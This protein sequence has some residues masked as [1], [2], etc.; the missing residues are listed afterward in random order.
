MRALLLVSVLGVT[1]VR[2]GG[3]ENVAVF[4]NGDSWASLAIANEYCAAR[5][6]PPAH[7]VVLRDL[8]S[9]EQVS[10]N[11]FREKILIP[12]LTELERRGLAAQ[13]DYVLYSSDFPTA[14]EVSADTAGRTFP[15]VITQPASITGL[16]FLYKFTLAKNPGYLGLNTNFYYRQP[17]QGPATPAMSGL[18]RDKYSAVIAKFQQVT[19]AFEER[20]KQDAA[21]ARFTADEQQILRD[22]RAA[23]E[24]FKGQYPAR[25]EARYDLAC[26]LARLGEMD[27]A[28]AE[29]RAAMDQG[30]W[31]M[32]RAQQDADFRELRER[33]GF[34]ELMARAR[35][36]KFDLWPTSGFRGNVGWI[37]TGAPVPAKEGVS[38]LLSAMLACTSGRGMGVSEAIDGLKR[39]VKADGTR[40][41]G[42]VYFLEN[43]DIRSTTRD[44]AFLRAVEKLREVG[45]SARV[46][47]GILPAKR[48]DVAGLTAGA[49]DFSWATS[50]STILPGAICEHLTSC[51][52]M[53]H[54]G[55]PQTPLTEF[56]RHGA[57]GASGTVREPYAIQAK[58][59][60]AFIHYHYAQ[61]CTLGE[62]FYQSV[63][64]PYQL[65][66]VGD[67]LCA[68]WKKR[69]EV[70][71]PGLSEGMTLRGMVTLK[72]EA[73]S[74]DGVAIGQFDLFVN[75]RRVAIAR[76]GQPLELNT[77]AFP[78]GAHT[79]QIVATGGDALASAGRL[80]VPVVIRNGTTDLRVE[81]APK[82]EVPWNQSL[83]FKARAAGA[84]RI[85]FRN[86]ARVVGEI[87]GAEGSLTVDPRVLGQGPVQLQPVAIFDADREHY[88]EPIRFRVT[89]PPFLAAK[90]VP[91]GKTLA[92]G[93]HV[94]R[95]GGTPAVVAKAE[96]DWLAKAG[97]Q[98]GTHFILEGWFQ[99]DRD[100][101]YQFQLRGA[102]G[103]KVVV[104]DLLQEWPRGKEWWFVPVPLAK[105]LHHVRIEGKAGP[106]AK[107]DA[108]FGG[109]GSYR[110]AGERFQHL[111]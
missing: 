69:I 53:L 84:K 11:D 107:L 89:P 85:V 12:G 54:E 35:D 106:E 94:T 16:T 22:A 96:G 70:K 36:V 30:W 76:S 75:G 78:D 82:G 17:R 109:P 91:A 19:N 101:V 15:P 65:L 74:R 104:D 28:L 32:R 55:D 92:N 24:T 79:L 103:M 56:L 51:G 110:L 98:S 87:G 72:P 27:A 38:Y 81:G 42:T 86:G 100:D 34:K 44:W 49:V 45:V 52:G 10:V 48:S 59:P 80:T 25:V 40:P 57:A 93:F 37:P 73:T 41:T 95:E 90:T 23:L 47:R 66:I 99:V 13:L 5:E 71:A 111:E 46:E 97:V 4:A 58:F 33:P 102:A 7:V 2:A 39:S 63:A 83:E 50:E 14:I 26:V 9:F 60:T 77:I 43:D 105:G 62:A 108:R 61:G 20:R 6:I 3:P 8:P 31:D 29:L 88:G 68:P 18:D 1:G 67:A 64:G 21:G